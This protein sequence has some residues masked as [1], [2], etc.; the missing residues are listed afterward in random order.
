MEPKCF[1]QA[2]GRIRRRRR[3][4]HSD[5]CVCRTSAGT[6]GANSTDSDAWRKRVYCADDSSEAVCNTGTDVDSGA[7]RNS[8]SDA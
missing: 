1:W 6:A 8:C 2:A 7:Y 3:M 4:L 5:V